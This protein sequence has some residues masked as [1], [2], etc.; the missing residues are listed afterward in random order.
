MKLPM[1][2]INKTAKEFNIDPKLIAAICVVE[3]EGDTWSLRYEGGWKTFLTTKYW[4]NM[5]KISDSTERICQQCS[6]G[7][8]QVMGT[9]ARE[10]GMKDDL[11]QLCRPDIGL[12]YGCKK[13]KTLLNKYDT[14]SAIS[15]YNAGT[16]KRNSDGK[17]RNQEYVDKVLKAWSEII[18]SE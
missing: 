6:W 11:T 10:L 14:E 4:A 18:K 2:L 9:V 15:A 17:F 13:L 16:P 12:F 7:L 3:S 8:M 5:V 1:D